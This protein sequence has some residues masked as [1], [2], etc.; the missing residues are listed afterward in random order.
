MTRSYPN[1][2]DGRKN[3]S[4]CD[5]SLTHHMLS[6]GRSTGFVRNLKRSLKYLTI[7]QES[8]FSVPIESNPE[9]VT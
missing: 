3:S 6:D 4:D 9:R 8:T 7:E 2:P 5:S 1:L